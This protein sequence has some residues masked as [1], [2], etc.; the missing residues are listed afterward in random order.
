MHLT[1]PILAR[2]CKGYKS[3]LTRV[4]DWGDE[5]LATVIYTERP[6]SLVETFR[7]SAFFVHGV[8]VQP[9]QQAVGESGFPPL[10][11]IRYWQTSPVSR[12]N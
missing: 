3:L 7:S 12:Q 5:S 8:S 2:Q 9:R 6:A 10:P 4:E 11:P 1:L